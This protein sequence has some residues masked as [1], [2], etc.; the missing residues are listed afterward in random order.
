MIGNTLSPLRLDDRK[1]IIYFKIKINNVVG[2]KLL[3]LRFGDR[4]RLIF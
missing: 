2:Y 1:H 4:L 3:P